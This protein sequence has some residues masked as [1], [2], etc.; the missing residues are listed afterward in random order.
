MSKRKAD[1]DEAKINFGGLSW[2]ESNLGVRS[3]VAV[4]GGKKLRLVEFTSEFV[5]HDWCR[6]GHVGYVLD[7][8]L[9]ITFPDRTERFTV[10]DGIIIL[11][12]EGERHK[13]R[14]IGA[15]AR[16]LLAEDLEQ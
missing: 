2:D 9:E 13:A 3:K 1:M 4:R 11:G 10:G 5:E 7:G 6:K 8:A 15:V 14:V 12:G 16:L